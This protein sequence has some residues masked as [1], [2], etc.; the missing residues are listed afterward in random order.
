[1]ESAY[2]T[3]RNSLIHYRKSGSGSRLAIC[4]HG[5]GT[6][7]D[8]FD[9]IAQ[10]VPGYTFIAFDLPF[11]GL[12]QWKE[13]DIKVDELVEVMDLC[14]EVNGR[15]F[16]LVG[17]SMGGRLSLS[18]LQYIPSRITRL[19]LLAP[20]GLHVNP[21]YWFATQTSIGNK[22]FY[23]AMHK[24]GGFVQLVR[25]SAKIHLVSDGVM[26]FI[27]R[28]MDDKTV[29]THVYQVW[30]A[31]R[32]FRPDLKKIES[33]ILQRK[34]PVTLIYGKFDNVIPFA[35]GQQFAKRLGA[36]SQF[37]VLDCGHQVLHIRNAQYIADSFQ[38]I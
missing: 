3:Y 24:P 16:A 27:D 36:L 28:Y 6:F 22:V 14:P 11:H 19:L 9:W 10:H 1:M 38:A 31:F 12:T 30:T 2:L 34:I 32:K 18:I 25:K 26:K 20:D 29:R 15:P 33:E 5:F 7:A 13:K 23:Q 8:T 17:Y 21:W 35:P 37:T 4:F